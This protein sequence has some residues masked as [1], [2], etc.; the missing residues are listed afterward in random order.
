[1]RASSLWLIPWL[2]LACAPRLPSTTPLGEG[3]LAR[4]E[5]QSLAKQAAELEAKAKKESGSGAP[6]A[7]PPE[8]PDAPSPETP[9]PPPPPKTAGET[10]PPEPAGAK[11][12]A[13]KK[14]ATAVVYAG[15]YVG[16]DT[17]TYKMEGMERDEKDDKARTRVEG[18][19]PDISVT[20]I[21]SGSG[22]DICTLKAQMTGKTGSFAAGQKC[23][24]SDGPGMTGTLTRGSA[25][26][27]DKKLVIDADF[28]IQ[29]GGEGDFKMSGKLHYHFEGT[30]K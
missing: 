6:D 8:T 16:S 1:M 9:A 17:S 14:P 20:F 12:P 15:E 13:G 3:P 2:A 23:W 5:S 18:A 11:A 7:P 30:R 26:F 25:S 28:D 21:D 4:A 29:V 24:G 22:K 19:G 10:P 27:E